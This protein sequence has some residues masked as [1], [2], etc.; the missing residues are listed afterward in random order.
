MFSPEAKKTKDKRQ[1]TKGFRLPPPTVVRCPLS[2]VSKCNVFA[3]LTLRRLRDNKTAAA[4]DRCPLSVVC[5]PQNV[6]L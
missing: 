4:P 3:S 1:R 2:V 6:M 5:C